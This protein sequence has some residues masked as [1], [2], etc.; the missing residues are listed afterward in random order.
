MFAAVPLAV[1][2]DPLSGECN[3]TSSTR[4]TIQLSQNKQTTAKQ[5]D[6]RFTQT[7]SETANQVQQLLYS[8]AD[9]TAIRWT[10]KLVRFVLA[11]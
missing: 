11:E 10:H 7:E 1:K 5:L 3:V 8:P 2:R 9:T 4:T 6:E